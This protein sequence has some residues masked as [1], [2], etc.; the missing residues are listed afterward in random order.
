MRMS[1]LFVR[2]LREAPSQAVLESHK[3][4]A[5]AG[6]VQEIGKGAFALLPYGLNAIRRMEQALLSKLP[7]KPTV[8]ELPPALSH[9]GASASGDDGLTFTD[10]QGRQIQL[11][12]GPDAGVDELIRQHFTSYKQLPAFI[13]LHHQPWSNDVYPGSGLLYSRMPLTLS[14]YGFFTQPSALEERR[15]QL[16][17]A[18]QTWLVDL[19]IPTVQSHVPFPTAHDQPPEWF[20]P[21]PHGRTTLYTCVSCGYTTSQQNA[22]FSRKSAAQEAPQPLERVKTPGCKTIDSLAEFLNIPKERTAKAV[23]LTATLGG[24][25]RFVIVIIPG[26]RELNERQL[27]KAAGFSAWRPAAE[28]E[29]LA[30]GVVPGYGSAVGVKGAF[31]AVDTQIPLSANLVAGANEADTHLLN[32]NY[33]RDYTADLVAEFTFPKPGDACPFCQ[34]K[35]R[36]ETC[37]PIA[38]IASPGFDHMVM[39]AQGQFTPLHTLACHISSAR[40]LAALA[41]THNDEHGLRM[42]PGAAP[43]QVYL[44]LLPDKEGTAQ[45]QADRLYQDLLAAGVET[46]YDD[47]NERAGVKF[48]DAD[49]TGIPL[50]ITVSQRGVSQ[51][52]VELKSRNDDAQP[53]IIPVEE[54]VPLVQRL[55]IK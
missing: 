55:L 48:N 17:E 14:L 39:D 44:A 40:L 45:P 36:S 32:V 24:K 31:V 15:E 37:A 50:R 8:L 30:A 10:A 2:T 41:E 43:F 27:A 18:I 7:V 54:I 26:D 52:V 46:L 33:G 19:E 25:E 28:E 21:H 22:R 3:L 35:L 51:G 23:F 49:L 42:P 11:P 20:F 1:S 47:R 5:R 13:S 9:E 38:Q 34:E 4:L 16:T 53:R 12:T 29:I 6:Y